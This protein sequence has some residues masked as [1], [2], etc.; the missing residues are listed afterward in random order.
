M[1]KIIS[2]GMFA[3]FL[4]LASGA[5][6]QEKVKEDVKDAGKD[7][8]KG[9]KKAAHKTAEVTSKGASKVL[10]KTVDGKAGPNGETVYIDGQSRYYW[11]DKKGHK[12]FVTEAELKTK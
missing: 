10:D 9:V 7:V 6:A 11:V 4:G 8:K 2:A 1:K 5:G 12:Q 3:L